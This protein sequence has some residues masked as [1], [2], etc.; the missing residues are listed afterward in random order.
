MTRD[1]STIL[2]TGGSR[3]IGR[4][5]VR[6]LAQAG[7]S[8]AFTY[9]ENRQAAEQLVDE[10]SP[11]HPRIAALRC[12]SRDLDAVRATV[13]E[14]ADRFGP[15]Y[16]LVNNAGITRD[17]ALVMMTAE[18]WQEV[19]DVDLSGVFNFC[20][21][22]IFGMSKRRSGRIVN[23]GSVSGVIGNRGQ[24]NYS[25][26]K[27]GVIGLSKALAKETASLGV[28]VNVVAPGYIDT[29]MLHNLPAETRRG[30]AEH[31]PMGRLGTAEEVASLVCY[32][33][34]ADSG[35]ITGQVFLVDGG[36]AI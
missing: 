1:A 21:S 35:Y 5:I 34:G 15:I 19:I 30:L 22:V 16:G 13:K 4:A 10:L 31:I 18:Q 8:V 26:A 29:E 28:T 33:L 24:V 23:I 2:V 11:S 9:R 27:A 20:K 17:R 7:R 12:D 14:V 6:L 25:A 3:G 32:L 36:I